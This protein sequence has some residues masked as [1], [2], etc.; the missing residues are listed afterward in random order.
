MGNLRGPKRAFPALTPIHGSSFSCT[1][2][3]LSVGDSD[4]Q[5]EQVVVAD[6]TDQAIIPHTEAPE[7]CEATL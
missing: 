1:I 4:N 5:N 6:V 2:C 7:R 3:L